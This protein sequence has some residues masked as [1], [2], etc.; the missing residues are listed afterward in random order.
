MKCAGLLSAACAALLLAGPV[1]AQDRPDL[2]E[3]GP[4]S[5]AVSRPDG[6]DYLFVQLTDTS[7]GGGSSAAHHQSVRVNHEFP[8]V[9]TLAFR[10]YE[11]DKVTRSATL[12]KAQQK[13]YLWARVLLPAPPSPYNTFSAYGIVTGCKGDAQ[14]KTVTGGT[15]LK[16]KFSCTN[17]DD[18]LNQL[19]VPVPLRPVITG[20]F[21][22]KLAFS[23]TATIP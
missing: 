17:A 19:A 15:Q 20:L 12:Y 23:N 21:G 1:N 5:M 10:L 4:T 11:P 22:N 2:L 14:A 16:Y 9:V 3:V 18:V 7:L 13:N 8:G 6:Q